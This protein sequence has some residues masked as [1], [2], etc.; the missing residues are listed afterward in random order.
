MK[1]SNPRKKSIFIVVVIIMFMCTIVS[2]HKIGLYQQLPGDPYIVVADAQN[3]NNK[4]G[5]IVVRDVAGA[6][7][8][9]YYL[10]F[11][12]N[13]AIATPSSV[14]DTMFVSLPPNTDISKLRI[15]LTMSLQSMSAEVKDTNQVRAF[16]PMETSYIRKVSNKDRTYTLIDT[17][18]F[19][20][21]FSNG[22][23]RHYHILLE[24]MNYVPPR[25]YALGSYSGGI[26]SV[27]YDDGNETITIYRSPLNT[28]MIQTLGYKI[29]PANAVI[30]PAYASG[31]IF[32]FSTAPNQTILVPITVSNADGNPVVTNYKVQ[33]HLGYNK[34][35]TIMNGD[36]TLKNYQGTSTNKDF[37]FK[38][39]VDE[40]NVYVL[41]ITR[42]EPSSG[43][44]IDGAI[45]IGNLGASTYDV[46]AYPISSKAGSFTK[47]K[48]GG[49]KIMDIVCFN[50]TLYGIAFTTSATLGGAS[51]NQ[52][53]QIIKWSDISSV[54][55]PIS[56]ATGTTTNIL[57]SFTANLEGNNI[58]FYSL[59]HTKY[60]NNA[61][62]SKLST[63]ISGDESTP[64]SAIFGR[65]NW[66]TSIS[67][68]S[69]QYANYGT[70]LNLPDIKR[71]FLSGSSGLLFGTDFDAQEA[72]KL[73]YFARLTNSN[74]N[75]VGM[76][77]ASI[78][79]KYYCIHNLEIPSS[80][81][82]VHTMRVVDLGTNIANTI[83]TL[84]GTANTP[85]TFNGNSANFWSTA[86]YTNAV[87]YTANMPYAVSFSNNN[88]VAYRGGCRAYKLTNGRIRIASLIPMYGFKVWELQ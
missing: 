67:I 50:N 1:K 29:E 34:V 66:N 72:P 27:G 9:N 13:P 31:S 11:R 39:A 53:Y 28:S 37:E 86:P 8:P 20:V 62:V 64:I 30:T 51:G 43:T 83:E 42:P 19:Y 47:M 70:F 75:P 80:V 17:V 65:Q 21:T 68:S 2:C 81:N 60:L 40:N 73:V 3:T 12:Q 25:I 24:I 69:P 22:Y 7:I 26:D 56:T 63:S 49:L 23:K 32:D 33:L 36:S 41:T 59:D 87:S 18:G 4:I 85:Q 14:T 48:T 16:Q 35:T 15:I 52:T 61:Q 44:N 74:R 58:V 71:S 57:V 5:S 78:G 38:I 46:Y 77:V 82:N 10:G 79:N 84:K 6:I 76:N 55:S 54:P 88:N 45:E